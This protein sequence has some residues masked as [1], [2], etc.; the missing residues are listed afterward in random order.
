MRMNEAPPEDSSLNPGAA[1][2]MPL[3]YVCWGL[4]TLKVALL[5]KI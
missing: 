3:D 4:L 1:I 5:G 2:K